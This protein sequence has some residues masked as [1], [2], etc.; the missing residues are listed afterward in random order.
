[1]FS[2]GCPNGLLFDDRDCIILRDAYTSM[3]ASSVIEDGRVA[4]ARLLAMVPARGSLDERVLVWL[5][6]MSAAWNAALPNDHIGAP[7]ITDIVPAISG[8]TIREVA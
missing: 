7:F 5:Q 3:D 1:M 2:S 6:S 4:T 8:S